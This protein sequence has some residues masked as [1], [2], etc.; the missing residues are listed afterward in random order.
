[1]RGLRSKSRG[2]RRTMQGKPLVKW[3]VRRRARSCPKGRS[4]PVPS[5]GRGDS[6]PPGRG[7]TL[8]ETML[9]SLILII[10]VAGLLPLFTTAIT[11]NE[12]QGDIATRTIE[13][14]QDKMEQ[15]VKL[16]F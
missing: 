1:M 4:G 13:Y 16:D 12:Q 15:L 11:Q 3:S 5:R 7:V 14:A 8:V 10:V 6:A 9:A 2:F